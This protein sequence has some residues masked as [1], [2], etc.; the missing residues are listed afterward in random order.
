M[1]YNDRNND[2]HICYCERCGEENERDKDCPYC[3]D[4]ETE[5]YNPTKI[6]NEL[7]ESFNVIFSDGIKKGTIQQRKQL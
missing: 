6:L 5:I 3:N 4:R 2:D 7:F 1:I